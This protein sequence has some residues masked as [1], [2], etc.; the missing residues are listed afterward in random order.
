MSS[1]RL[2]PTNFHPTTRAWT[3]SHPKISAEALVYP[4]FVTDDAD[5]THI[6]PIASLPGV[7]RYPVSAVVEALR[8]L[9]AKG[10]AT[11][12]LFGVPTRIPKD[13]AGSAAL[14][15]N[16]PVVQALKVLS[17]AF[18]DLVLA[19]DVCLCAYTSHGH[20][21]ILHGDESINNPASI[22]QLAK[23]A[24]HYARAGAH[25]VAPSDMMDNRVGSIKRA[26]EATPGCE[27]VSVMA[28]SAK[29]ASAF[30]GPFRDAAK[31]APGKGDRKGYQ[32][33][34]GSRKLA[35]RAIVR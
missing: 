28:Y 32:L 6:E 2:H 9:V 30:Y 10:L 23:V 13:N 29:F 31:S 3:V 15:P 22:E 14:D 4:V 5:P 11:V 7:S 19:C 20:C 33:P 17:A 16:T 24:V 27:R 26:L 25:I 21:G 12:I 34:V 8:P 35:R 1:T 18:P